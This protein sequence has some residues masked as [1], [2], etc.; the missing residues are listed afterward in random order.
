M[1]LS[2]YK[3]E[4]TNRELAESTKKSYI[5]AVKDFLDFANG[6][7]LTQ[8]LLID[9]KKQLLEQYA[10]STANTKIT[11]INN[12]LSF[13]NK[14]V[15]VKQENI[16]RNNVLDNVLTETDFDRLIRMADT[17][18]KE[19]ERVIMLILYY[20]GIRISE[21]ENVT[22]EALKDGYIDIHNKGKHRRVPINRKLSQVLKKYVADVGIESGAIIVNR[23]GEPLSRSYIFRQLKWIG[24][25]ARVKKSKVYPHSFR[26]LFAK[27]WLRHN[28]NN[29]MA[30]ADLLGHSSLETTR[31]Y[32]TLSTDEQRDTINF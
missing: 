6:A 13:L 29:T 3:E 26:H 19:R 7:D 20:T 12:Y 16:Q 11:I 18:G 15:A 23:S 32:T 2:E 25:Q 30:L 24:G 9:Y 8:S 22:V 31:I 21:L 28:N 10:T 17:R 5:R 27:Q 1:N 14:D 4:L